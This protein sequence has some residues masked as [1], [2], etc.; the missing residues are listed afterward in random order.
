MARA[1]PTTPPPDPAPTAELPGEL[2]LEGTKG[3]LTI[4]LTTPK[5]MSTRYEVW[6]SIAKSEPKAYGAALGLSSAAIRKHVRWDHDVLGFGGA[7]LDWLLSEGVEWSD[8]IKA[9]QI[10]W[11]R[12]CRELV[13]EREVKAA[14]G[15]TDPEPEGSTS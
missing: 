7:V 11:V 15:F 9:G 8:A 2:T 1:K 3:K 12:M 13:S 5:S 4:A 6:S 14:E 10:A